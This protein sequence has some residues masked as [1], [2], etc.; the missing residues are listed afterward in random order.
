MFIWP[1]LV[2]GAAIYTAVH[3]FKGRS[4]RKKRYDSMERKIKTRKK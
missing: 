4:E 3:F 2:I 1:C